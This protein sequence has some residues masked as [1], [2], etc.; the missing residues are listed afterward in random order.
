LGKER[1]LH[2]TTDTGSTPNEEDFGLQIGL[3]GADE[4]RS[5]DRQ[6]TVPELRNQSLELITHE[7]RLTQH[8]EVDRP[9]PRDRIGMGKISPMT[10]Q[11]PGPQVE[12]KKKM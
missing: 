11:A 7:K 2:G 10:T 4:V 5:D 12:A 3:I 8:E 9:T 1:Y 6:D